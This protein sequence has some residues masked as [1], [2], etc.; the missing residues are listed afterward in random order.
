MLEISLTYTADADLS[1]MH[2]A[3]FIF[4]ILILMVEELQAL[5][6]NG[7]IF[8]IIFGFFVENHLQIYQQCMQQALFFSL[9]LDS[10]LKITY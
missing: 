5:K 4:L 3:G 9:L 8:L 7:L 1:A 2:A 10:L 6:A